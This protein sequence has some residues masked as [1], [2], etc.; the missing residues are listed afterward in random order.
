VLE[1]GVIIPTL[2]AATM[3]LTVADWDG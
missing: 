1:D 3:L 2:L